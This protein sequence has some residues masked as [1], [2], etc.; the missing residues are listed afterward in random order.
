MVF[1]VDGNPQL[2]SHDWSMYSDILNM[3]ILHVGNMLPKCGKCV[4]LHVSDTWWVMHLPH[5]R[6]YRKCV[7]DTWTPQISDTYPTKR[8]F[9]VYMIVHILQLLKGNPH[10]GNV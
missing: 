4:D 3:E 9:H 10:V 8:F 1:K 5:V 6:I 7:S 2:D